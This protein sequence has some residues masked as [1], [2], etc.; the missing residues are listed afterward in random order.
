MSQRN[1]KYQDKF[2]S[3]G[4]DRPLQYHFLTIFGPDSE[5]GEET[6]IF[7]NL[8]LPNPAMTVNQ[9]EDKLNELNIPIPIG[10]LAD[11]IIDSIKNTGNL[12]VNYQL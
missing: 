7:D 10:F 4:W 8:N 2:I 9:I 11:L 12:V 5:D 6:I 1:Y 3:A